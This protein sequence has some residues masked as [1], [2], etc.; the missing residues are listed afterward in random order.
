MINDVVE[1]LW[2]DDPTYG[3]RLALVAML[4]GDDDTLRS[5]EAMISVRTILDAV[6]N[7]EEPELIK[8]FIGELECLNRMPP[9]DLYDYARAQDHHLN[10][11]L[12]R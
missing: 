2:Q 10:Q 11:A 7:D 5:V 9:R 12:W 8:T 4:S 3:D 1:V 6:M